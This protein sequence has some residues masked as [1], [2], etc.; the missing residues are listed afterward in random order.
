MSAYNAASAGGNILGPHLFSAADKPGYKPGIRDVLA[1]FCALVGVF[2]LQAVNL[3]FLNKLQSRRRVAEGKPAHL[4][5]YSMTTKY[6]GSS[7]KA[8][9]AD[10]EGASSVTLGDNAFLDVSFGSLSGCRPH[11]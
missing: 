1:I 10:A 8:T 4:I 6:L 9:E 7:A 2:S 5:D 3:F 11:F